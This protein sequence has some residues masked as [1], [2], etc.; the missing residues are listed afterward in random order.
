MGMGVRDGGGTVCLNPD[1]P[2]GRVFSIRPMRPFAIFI[3][4]Y[5]YLPRQSGF[6][7]LIKAAILSFSI[8]LGFRL[9]DH[10]PP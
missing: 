10:N 4:A 2:F 8:N 7:L 1:F 5:Y 6:H 9:H 3:V